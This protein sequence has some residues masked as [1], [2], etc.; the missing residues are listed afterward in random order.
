MQRRNV[1]QVGAWEFSPQRLIFV[2]EGALSN[3]FTPPPQIPQAERLPN[4]AIRQ[5]CSALFGR[6]PN[7]RYRTAQNAG[8]RIGSDRAPAS[9]PAPYKGSSVSDSA[10][11]GQLAKYRKL[12]V[13]SNVGYMAGTSNRLVSV[14]RS[15]SRDPLGPHAFPHLVY[16]VLRVSRAFP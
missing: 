8:R 5:G 14:S 10:H 6:A 15:G 16:A 13:A 7:F 2:C 12:A 9:L 11:S 1:A 4:T 3:A